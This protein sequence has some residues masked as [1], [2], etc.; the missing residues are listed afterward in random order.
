M[1]KLPAFQFYPADWRKDPGVQSLSYHDRGVWFEILCLMHE[2]DQRGKLLLNGKA[3]PEDALAR[4]L[5]L[6]KQVTTKT[7]TTLIE[8]G[9]A[10][11]DLETG[12]LMCRRMVRDENLRK[13]RQES[14]KMGGNP[15][16]LKQDSNQKAKPG[17]KQIST[18][19]S[20]SST[21]VSSSN[22]KTV[23]VVEEF[24]HE[25]LHEG[26][27]T[28]ATTAICEGIRNVLCQYLN[29]PQTAGWKTRAHVSEIALE[30]ADLGGTAEQVLEFIKTRQ[31]P[32]SSKKYW[33]D[34]FLNWRASQLPSLKVV[35]RKFQCETCQDSGSISVFENKKFIRYADC[36]CQ[37]RSVA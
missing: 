7:I 30:L 20:S 17:V 28:N 24:P 9:V 8:Y 1:S 23:V 4:L 29:I 10:S 2:S 5:G 14:G 35:E 32:P 37:K 25:T 27:T 22:K 16:L 6:D 11:Y 13:I 36:E 19:S 31:K 3:M 12:A 21:S 15:V 34:D 26:P 33:I 18:P